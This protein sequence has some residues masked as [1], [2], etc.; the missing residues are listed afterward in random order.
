MRIYSTD[1]ITGA[2][3]ATLLFAFSAFARDPSALNGTWTLVPAKCD[4]AGATAIFRSDP[5]LFIPVKVG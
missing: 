2:V 4:F 3:L 1:A 5:A